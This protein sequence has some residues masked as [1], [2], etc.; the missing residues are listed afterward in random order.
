MG[1]FESIFKNRPKPVGKFEGAWK[2]LNGYQPHFSTWSGS[3]Y[4]SDLIRA[5]INIRATHIGKLK[6]ETVG[7][8]KPALQNKLAHGPNSFQTWEQFLRRCSTLLDIF[9]SLILIPIFDD[10]GE[11]S[12][13]YA[14]LVNRCE[15]VQ[16]GGKP[17]VRYRFSSGQEAAIELDLC[18][19]M[20][21]FSY[22]DDFF[23][24]SNHALLP[25][26]DL[27]KIQGQAIKESVENAASYK[28]IAQLANFSKDSDLVKLRKAFSEENFGRE[29]DAGGLLLFPNTFQNIQKVDSKP[30]VV[31]ADQLKIIRAGVYEYFN[32][33]EDVLTGQAYGD[34][35]AAWFDAVCEPFAIQFEQVLERMI[36][37]FRERSL[38]N[39]VI[40]TANRIQY[41]STSEKLAVASQ[42]ADR[43][44][45]TRN[46]LREIFNLAPLPEPLGDQ[47]PARGEYYDITAEANSGDSGAGEE[48]S[49]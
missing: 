12:G 24:E 8:A 7:A 18:G 2:L 37:T 39:R 19:I 15:I 29:A 16:Y 20:N 38:G 33:N 41:A 27:M 44:L 14:P 49:E 31:D 3:I 25:T 1:L 42:M 22:K 21:H 5:A 32:V 10:W 48:G 28:F 26:L 47:I 36:F 46:E 23:G 43:G 17:Y 40:V 45:M 9:N 11:I 4:E 30:F 13:I 35:F 34:K 6:V